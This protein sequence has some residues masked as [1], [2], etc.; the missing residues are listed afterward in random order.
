VFRLEVKKA[1]KKII[2]IGAGATM[3]GTTIMGAMAASLASY[4]APF[5]KDGKFDG[6]LVV[7]DQAKAEDVIGATDIA[8]SLQYGMTTQKTVSTGGATSVV[9]SGDALKIAESTNK[10]EFGEVL[11]TIKTSVTG[12]DLKALAGGSITNEKGTYAYTE[13]IDLPPAQVKYVVDPDDDTNTVADYLVI[14]QSPAYTYKMTFS[15]ALKTDATATTGVL[16]DIDNKDITML[17]KKYTFLSPKRTAVTPAYTLT[18]M[19]GATKDIM[20]EG[21]TKTFTINGKDYEVTVS[22][23]GTSNTEDKAKF[24]IN[25]ETTDSLASGGTYKL[26]DGTQI[27]VT[28]ILRNEAGKAVGNKVEFNLGA[29]KI[30]IKDSNTTA[31]DWG[32]TCQ[33]TVGSESLGNVVCNIISSTDSGFTVAAGGEIQIS[34]IDLK[35]T[36]SQDIYVASGK[37]ASAIADVNEGEVGNFVTG[38]FDYEYKGLEIPKTEEIK[39]TPSG[40]DNYK[41]DFTNK[42]GVKYDTEVFTIVPVG[43]VSAGNVTLGKTSGTT[44]HDVVVQEGVA[45]ND[46]DYFVV[47]KNKYSRILQFKDVNTA[48]KII[49]IKDVGSDVTNEVT[50]TDASLTGNLVLDG[51]TY[52]VNISGPVTTASNIWVDLDANGAIGGNLLNDNNG[53]LWTELGAAINLSVDN[54]AA[55]QT[56]GR[57]TVMSEDKENNA[58]KDIIFQDLYKTADSKLDINSTSNFGGSVTQPAAL[59]ATKEDSDLYTAYTKYG[60]KITQDRKS[61]TSSD[62]DDLTIVYP[63][64]QVFAA[65]YVTSGVT[66]ATTS[67]ATGEIMTTEIVK[68]DVGAS[69]LASEVAGEETKH[70]LILVGGP[71]ANAAAAVIMGNPENCVAGFE[72]GKAK[73][74]LYENSGKVAMLVAGATALDTRGAAQFVAQYE[75]N[76]ATFSG[77]TDEIALTVTSLSS[78]TASI[79]TKTA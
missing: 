73:V 16:N 68:I 33:V 37:G 29:D 58:G 50:Y 31:A 21:A 14:N 43:T 13:T 24:S 54:A 69:V 1:I 2:A 27:G 19:G 59:T 72:A 63:D 71:C 64:S 49:K 74:K 57:I 20:E 62:Q 39:L 9:V 18:L 6:M 56:N 51:N 67:G 77:A 25:G 3:V 78:I 32:T 7:G 22:W 55:T 45:I 42:A 75:K 30:E 41:L 28:D 44:L 35:Y 65:V 53:Q 38:A 36:P 46:E 8:M 26:S 4:P 40:N 60:I 79:P 52:K 5:I 23:I 15:P 47:S 66:T 10:L 12:S 76:K 34:E 48:D 70:N 61:S 17:G 11:N